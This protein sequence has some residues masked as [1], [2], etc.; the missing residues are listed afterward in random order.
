MMKMLLILSLF[1]KNIAMNRDTPFFGRVWQGSIASM[2]TVPILV[3]PYAG[4]FVANK[5]FPEERSTGCIYISN[6]TASNVANNI[7]WGEIFP[8]IP[9]DD[10]QKTGL[11]TW[12]PAIKG[13][14]FSVNGEAS[15][16]TT[17]LYVLKEI[18][19]LPEN[20][21]ENGAVA[22]SPELIDRVTEL[23]KSLAYQPDIFP[24]AE[25]SIQLEFENSK[26]DYL[27]F[28]LFEDG[29]VQRFFC[30]SNGQN[31]T[32]A[33]S[34]QGINNDYLKKFFIS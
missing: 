11:L 33:F 28:E 32:T 16:L 7:I 27:E 31:E 5:L 13:I 12:T 10:N 1:T 30:A 9:T 25:E 14:R 4:S 26:G 29:A 17:N 18:R 34:I 24:T 2:L 22:F 8:N 6:N 21:N 3:L 19:G 23:I 20:W 15:K